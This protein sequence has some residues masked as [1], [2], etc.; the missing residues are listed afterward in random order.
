[1][2]KGKFFMR[3]ICNHKGTHIQKSEADTDTNL[4]LIHDFNWPSIHQTTI[5]AFRKW[6]KYI[7][8]LCEESKVNLPALLGKWT[9][10]GNKYIT[11]WQWLLSHDFHT[12]YIE[13]M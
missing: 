13:N 5:A 8:K 3:Y 2:P 9:L 1:M 7:I 11:S 12:L 4:H 10:D 6:K